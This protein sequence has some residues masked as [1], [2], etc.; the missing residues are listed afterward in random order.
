M[1]PITRSQTPHTPSPHSSIIPTSKQHVLLHSSNTHCSALVS[2]QYHILQDVG[3]KPRGWWQAEDTIWH[4][5]FQILLP[6]ARHLT[7][8]GGGVATGHTPTPSHFPAT[9][10][11]GGG[12]LGRGRGAS[13]SGGGG[14]E[15]GL[16]DPNIYG[17]K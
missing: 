2:R 7:G 11:E 1:L 16:P 13:L 9:F 5:H 14:G 4:S 17:L 3:H 12:G 10:R 15:G 6:S 8:G